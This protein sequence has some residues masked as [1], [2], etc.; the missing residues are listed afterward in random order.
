MLEDES[1]DQIETLA[2]LQKFE[3][4][5]PE[6]K[7]KVKSSIPVYAKSPFTPPP[8]SDSLDTED[9]TVPGP[10][11]SPIKAED[12]PR[13]ARL[14][15]MTGPVESQSCTLVHSQFKPNLVRQKIVSPKRAKYLS[16][17][18]N[19]I[20]SRDGSALVNMPHI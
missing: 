20:K 19:D 4:K 1:S 7:V 15:H 12:K 18:L 10:K 5:L 14:I 3:G 11:L 13:G 8:H 9:Q 6:M 17:K 16:L 2:Q